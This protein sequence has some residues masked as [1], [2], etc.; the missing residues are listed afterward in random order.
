[1]HLLNQHV[2]PLNAD[3]RLLINEIDP[4]LHYS[5]DIYNDEGEVIGQKDDDTE[6]LERKEL[7]GKVRFRVMIIHDGCQMGL[8][9]PVVEPEQSKHAL[10]S[11]LGRA[12]ESVLHR[13][14]P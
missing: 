5:A 7:E 1:M 6:R 11:V 10:A 13:I 14:A 8:L 12:A 4:A 9:S 2:P 3:V